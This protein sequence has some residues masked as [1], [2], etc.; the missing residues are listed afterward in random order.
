MAFRDKKNT[1]SDVEN[2]NNKF[3]NNEIEHC[4]IKHEVMNDTLFSTVNS[5]GFYSMSDIN[6]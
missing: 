3:N 2:L 4:T 6:K 1:S 5:N